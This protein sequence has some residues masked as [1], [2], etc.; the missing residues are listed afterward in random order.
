MHDLLHELMRVLDETQT[1]VVSAR[2][3]RFA[4]SAAAR[5]WGGSRRTAVQSF[6]LDVQKFKATT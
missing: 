5:V 3:V 6:G 2:I 4:E 1:A